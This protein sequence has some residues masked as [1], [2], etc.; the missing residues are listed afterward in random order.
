MSN[1]VLIP[2]GAGV[3]ILAAAAIAVVFRSGD[4]GEPPTAIARAE[5]DGMVRGTVWVANED[6]ASLTAIDAARNEVLT[7][8]TGIE[9][10]HNLQ[11][12]PDGRS[13]WAV[14][15][16]ESQAVMVDAAD[17]S[18]HG[19]VATGK[20]PAHVVVTPDG[21]T[22]YTTNGADDTV[23]AIDVATMKQVATVPV[24]PFPHGLRPSPD[25][26]WVYV[27]NAKGTTVSV[28]DT[29]KNA[30]VADIEVGKAP[31]QIAFSP[32]GRFAYASLNGENAVAKIDVAR[33]TLVTHA[34]VGVGP[35]QT[36]V[37]PDGRYLLVAN[38]GTEKRPST[39][40]SIVETASFKV[41]GTVET[42]RGAHGVVVD[43]SSRHAYV[44]NIYGGEV[45]VLDLAQRK[46]VAR[47]P[48]GEKPNGISFSPVVPSVRPARSMRLPLRHDAEESEHSSDE[49]HE[50]DEG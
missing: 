40:V 1:R 20:E 13:V 28:I 31:V 2:A 43:P 6:G 42:G 37:S 18:L 26:R 17:F 8:L 41:V 49:T 19:A 12:S 48:V 46:V 35:I 39:T 7:T 36:Y 50:M 34:M 47:I 29:V 44:T 5:H 33:R 21:R 15:G 24:G 10:P 4:G 38:Q 16:H 25:G 9:G 14:S 45:A 30:R 32:D 23:S 27:A 3:A 11:A 22:V